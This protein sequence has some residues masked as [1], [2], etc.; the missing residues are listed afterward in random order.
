MLLV[1]S[2]FAAASSAS[3]AA[4]GRLE[5]CAGV[6]T[7]AFAGEQVKRQKRR[8]FKLVDRTCES[9]CVEFY[10][11]SDGLE[12]TSTFACYSAA[13]ADARRNLQD[14]IN[15][16]CVVQ[17]GWRR[18]WRGNRGERIVV[19]Y[20]ADDTG[21]RP[22]KIFWYHRGDICFAFIQAGSLR[23]AL[24]FERSKQGR[25]AMYGLT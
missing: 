22:A 15:E 19:I 6:S 4:S 1:C 18:N 16:G 9:G 12:V 10:Q 25:E 21:S 8:T 13:A 23:L 3:D 7:S 24:E 14:E 11:S 5:Y 2:G 17:R 20:P